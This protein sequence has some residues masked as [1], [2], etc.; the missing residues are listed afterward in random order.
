MNFMRGII[1]HEGEQF[2]LDLGEYRLS[3]PREKVEPPG[4]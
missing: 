2:Y 3:I 1:L 4:K